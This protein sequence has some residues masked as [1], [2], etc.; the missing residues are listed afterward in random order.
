MAGS[1]LAGR[2][3]ILPRAVLHRFLSV[4]R[5]ARPAAPRSI[6]VAHHLLLGDTLM[7]TALLAKL[8]ERHPQARIAMTVPRAYAP[9]YAG[10]PYGVEAMAFDPRDPSTLDPLLSSGGFDLAFVPGDN[11]HAWLAAAAGARW[12]VAHD[13]DRPAAKNWPVDEM[14]PYPATPASWADMVAMLADGPAPRPF[15]PDDWPAPGCAPFERPPGRY[16]VLHV[17][18]GSVLRLWNREKWLAVAHALAQA[19][20]RVVWSAGRGEEGEVAGIDPE[21]RFPSLAGTLDLPQLWH[22]LKG[23]SVLLCPDTG[24]AH[25]GRAAG[26]PVVTLYGPGSAVLFGPGDF[27]RS[28]PSLAVTVDPF[29]CRDQR[30]L[31][32]REIAW[33]RRCQR[34]PAQCPAPRCMHAIGT[35]AVV[36]AA[37]DCA[38]HA[39]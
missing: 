3:R 38:R 25:L 29:E 12:I 23:A 15:R 27:W 20:L 32:K 6:L 14:R 21:R 37:L 39:G 7:L 22:L 28:M 31:F 18:A 19:G 17:G 34:S 4:R 35:E 10:R 5:R 24:I 11:R 1:R 2:L 16:A 13:G 26:A 33:V 9:L 8:R 30:T 36:R